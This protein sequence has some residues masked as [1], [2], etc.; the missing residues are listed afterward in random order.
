MTIELTQFIC[1]NK[2][3]TELN[4]IKISCKNGFFIIKQIVFHH[5][6]YQLDLNKKSSKNS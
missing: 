1:L 3:K 6:N 2:I 4:F 5:K